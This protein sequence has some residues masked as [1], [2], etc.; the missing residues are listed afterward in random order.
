MKNE[1]V[2]LRQACVTGSVKSPPGGDTDSITVSEPV[3][4]SRV[5][6]TPARAKN[7]A[8]REAR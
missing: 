5:S 7:P 3:L 4:P 6:T 2:L 1:P 8:M